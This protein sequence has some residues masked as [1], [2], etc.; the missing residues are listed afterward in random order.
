[1]IL[2]FSGTGN[3]RYVAEKLARHL[4]E[5]L[6]FIPDCEAADLNFDG[7]TLGFVFPVYSWGVPPIV[8]DF[9]RN[10][11]DSFIRTVSGDNVR[12]WMVCTCGDETAMTP[13]M[14]EQCWR[15][16]LGPL[17]SKVSGMWSVTMPNTYVLLPGFDVDPENIVAAKLEA[18]PAR[19]ERIAHS[20][21]EG[22]WTVDVVRGSNPRFKSGVIFPLFRKWGIF[23]KHWRWTPE[24]LMCGKCAKAC[25]VNNIRIVTG[26]PVWG[27]KCLSCL[28]C[29]HICPAHAVSYPP[30]TE[31]KGQY[32]LNGSNSQLLTNSN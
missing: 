26:H 27:S 4:S 25:P 3:S 20:I 30:F 14:F 24:C 29:Y 6:A 7:N 13:E 15:K 31:N 5:S 18:A 8:L 11:S 10:L 1:M 12:V 19:I 2:Y 32:R 23:P 17:E 9:V 22:E 21:R 28:A 16:R